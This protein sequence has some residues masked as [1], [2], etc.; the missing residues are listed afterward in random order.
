[1]TS[2]PVV[3]DEYATVAKLQ[4][5]FSI[6][7]VGDG[8]LKCADRYGY[9]R[10]PPNGLLAAELRTILNTPLPGLVV[11]IP[12]LNPASPKYQ[13][14][15]RHKDRFLKYL[16]P[17]V[18]YGSA[19]ISRQDSSPWIACRAY[20]EGIQRCWT[21]KKI[22]LV[23]EPTNK[24]VPVIAA[25]A[26]KL[27]HIPCVSHGAYAHLGEYAQH[28][29]SVRPDVAVLS[30]GVSATCLAHRLTQHGMQALDLGSIGGMLCRLL[31][32]E[33]AHVDAPPTPPAV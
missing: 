14:W 8:E 23:C 22:A 17:E 9:R 10:E 1:M 2:W 33:E 5:G 11:G 4:Q 29:L 26:Q 7:R 6:A 27:Y 25:T 30:H 3:L 19:F 16:A 24:L 21:D 12:T 32:Q 18:E 28:V 13:N 31:L 20:A 15:L